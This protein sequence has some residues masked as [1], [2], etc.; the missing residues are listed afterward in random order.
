M[1]A[2]AVIGGRARGVQ[3]DID[4]AASRAY[5]LGANEQLLE[6]LHPALALQ[7]A[8]ALHPSQR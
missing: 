5:V 2:C 4:V 7:P 3:L 8:L 6:A 1:P